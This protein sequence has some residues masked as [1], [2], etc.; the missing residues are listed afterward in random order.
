MLGSFRKAPVIAVMSHKISRKQRAGNQSEEQSMAFRQ[1][2]DPHGDTGNHLNP[3]CSNVLF[4]LGISAE[5]CFSESTLEIQ[6][7][8]ISF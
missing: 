4:P 5:L 6:N 3:V 1:Q 2:L 7:N 8:S